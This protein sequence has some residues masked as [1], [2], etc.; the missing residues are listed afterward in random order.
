MISVT[1]LLLLWS[2]ILFNLFITLLWH[3]VLLQNPNFWINDNLLKTASTNSIKVLIYISINTNCCNGKTYHTH[4]PWLHTFYFFHFPDLNSFRASNNPAKSLVRSPASERTT[5]VKIQY[6]T[7]CLLLS[8]NVSIGSRNAHWL[9]PANFLICPYV[10]LFPQKDPSEGNN[11]CTRYEAHRTSHSF[12]L[13][14]YS[15]YTKIYL[16]LQILDPISFPDI[17]NFPTQTS[18]PIRRSLSYIWGSYS[19][20]NRALHSKSFKLE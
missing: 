9:S 7:I 12:L 14:N 11:A 4:S 16:L 19:Y 13:I 5:V 15:H 20:A 17:L 3:Y 6:S 8:V 10:F 2:D 18:R 1:P